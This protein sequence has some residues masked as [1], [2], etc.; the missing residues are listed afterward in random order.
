[1][2]S[3]QCPT[4]PLYMKHIQNIHSSLYICIHVTINSRIL[5]LQLKCIYRFQLALNNYIWMSSISCLI[6]KQPSISRCVVAH[7]IS[8]STFLFFFVHFFPHFPQLAELGDLPP[9]CSR[10]DVCSLLLERKPFSPVKA[11]AACSPPRF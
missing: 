4:T 5:R 7:L 1:M 2:K 3:H 8:L 6:Q 10:L 9:Q 11:V